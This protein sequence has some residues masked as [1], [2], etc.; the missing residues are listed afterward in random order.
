MRIHR[1][2]LAA[3]VIA[4]SASGARAATITPFNDRPVTIGV[5]PG[6][7]LPIQD[8]L[9]IVFG[10]GRVDAADDQQSAAMW[11]V[12]GKPATFSAT[13]AFEFTGNA[14]NLVVGLWSGSDSSNLTMV[15]I[16]NG[17]AA[18]M[19]EVGEDDF[20]TTAFLTWNAAGTKVNIGGDCASVNCRSYSGLDASAFGFYLRVPGGPTYY[21]SDQLNGGVARSLA[22][23]DGSTRD[24]VIAFEDGTD[25]DFNDAVLKVASLNQVPEPGSMLL[26]G[27]GLAGLARAIRRR[28][29]VGVVQG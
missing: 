6:N 9:D 18:G 4:L 27:T 22:Y 12:A 23:R 29:S 15:D 28:S 10:D 1:L 17:S 7:E 20:P 8:I 11:S 3:S 13:M 5:A 24:W 25:G 2:L 21:T 19:N 14:N 16:F 26:L